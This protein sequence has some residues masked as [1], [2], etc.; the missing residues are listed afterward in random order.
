MP[1]GSLNRFRKLFMPSG[2]RL[3]LRSI[4][5]VKINAVI[6]DIVNGPAMAILNQVVFTRWASGVIGSPSTAV[7]FVFEF[8]VDTLW[9]LL[10]QLF[11]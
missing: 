3:H 6:I 2:L 4:S 9:T 11:R 10:F 8:W 5:I 1:N 7:I